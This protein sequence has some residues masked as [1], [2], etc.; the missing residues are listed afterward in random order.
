MNLIIKLSRASCWI[1]F[2]LDLQDT[3]RSYTWGFDSRYAFKTV[4]FY[5]N[6]FGI[7]HV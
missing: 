3:C 2:T 7:Y 5:D 1:I 4:M 6:S